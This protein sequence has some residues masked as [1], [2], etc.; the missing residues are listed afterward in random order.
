MLS[1]SQDAGPHWIQNRPAPWAQTSSLQNGEK[2]IPVVHKAP[3]L[4][5]LLRQPKQAKTVGHTLSTGKLKW[6]THLEKKT[7]LT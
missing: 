5:V 4:Y 1:V 7:Q 2:E 3:G 6:L